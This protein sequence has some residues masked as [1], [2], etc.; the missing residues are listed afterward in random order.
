[1]D[2][3]LPLSS[4]QTQ[5]FAHQ[6]P[7]A[8]LASLS[9]ELALQIV[10]E[11]HS[12]PDELIRLQSVNRQFL[13][14]CRDNELWRTLVAP[15]LPGPAEKA[16]TE[17][18]LP[19]YNDLCSMPKDAQTY[20]AKLWK[21]PNRAMTYQEATNAVRAFPQNRQIVYMA[22]QA[23]GL[24]LQDAAA[25]LQR[26]KKIV[27]AA[28]KQFGWALK[29]ADAGLQRDKEIVFAAVKQYGQALQY[30]APELQRDK[31]IVLA[32][33]KKTGRAL[34]AAAAELQ[35]DKE[36]VLAAIRQ[37]GRALQYAASQF[38]SNKEVAL[39]AIKQNAAA[40]DYAA[41]ELQRD[42]DIIRATHE[43]WRT[44]GDASN[45]PSEF[46]RNHSEIII[47]AIRL[48]R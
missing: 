9:D 36:V 45:A 30:A 14:V 17:G 41:P 25:N 13:R 35:H 40:F 5:A 29:F 38:R 28:V 32:A 27:L 2:G 23:N 8:T 31:E 48:I 19:L 26:D 11:T 1:M 12:P 39:E 7:R 37:N 20:L 43:S 6:H 33:V 44:H 18:D 16:H 15:R 22:A 47:A 10:K 3:K 24:V 42:S 4:H 34:I 21:S 46:F